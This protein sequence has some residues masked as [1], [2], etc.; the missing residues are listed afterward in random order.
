MQQGGQKSYSR[1]IPINRGV[2]TGDIPSPICFLVALDKLLKDHGGLELGMQL[3]D[4]IIFSDIE[5][6]DDAALPTDDTQTAS[7]QLTN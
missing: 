2:I 1:K 4:E 5:F 3:T 6:A 7:V